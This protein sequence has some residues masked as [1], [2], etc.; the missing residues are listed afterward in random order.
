VR[1]RKPGMT[2][3]EWQCRNWLYFTW[4]SGD[5]IVEQ[6]VHNIDVINWVLQSHPVRAL[7]IGGRQVRTDPKYGNI[8]DHFAVEFTY[9]NDV[10]VMSTCRQIDGCSNRIDEWVRGTK[11]SSHP[12]GEI[13]GPQPFTYEGKEPRSFEYVQEHK[14]LIACIRKGEPYNEGRQVAE[15]TLCAIMG[16]ISAYTGR[17]IS[18]DW[19]LKNSKL[20]LVPKDPRFGPHPVDPVAVP[21]QT[22]PV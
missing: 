20:D 18:W 12:G 3:M 7:A 9:P 16:R 22:E 5:H 19:A 15:S 2:D 6:H 4:L 10:V 1:E 13:A 21:G 14:D 8:F 17:T 11:G